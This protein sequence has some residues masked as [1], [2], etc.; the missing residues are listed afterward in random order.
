MG[1]QKDRFSGTGLILYWNPGSWH[2][3]AKMLY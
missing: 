2:P 3:L 1:R